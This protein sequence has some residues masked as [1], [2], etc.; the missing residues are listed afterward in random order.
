MGST[1]LS[2]DPFDNEEQDM[3]PHILILLIASA[4]SFQANALE[5]VKVKC[6]LT[7]DRIVENYEGT[8]TFRNKTLAQVEIQTE[9]DDDGS[10]TD[11]FPTPGVS[12]NYQPLNYQMK[13]EPLS[14]KRFTAKIFGRLKQFYIVVGNWPGCDVAGPACD[15]EVLFSG[16]FNLKSSDAAARLYFLGYEI[17]CFKVN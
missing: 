12:L 14:E 13:F 9:L 7:H 5:P 17:T 2:I 11:R 4:I 8:N 6:Q 10:A 1:I 15:S 3:K 16:E